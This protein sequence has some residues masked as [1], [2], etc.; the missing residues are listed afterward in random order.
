MVEL[1][2]VRL[3][4][5]ICGAT[6][7]G[8]AH[9]V[10]VAQWHGWF[11]GEYEPWFLNSG[12]AIVFTLSC[13][14]VASMLIALLNRPGRFVRGIT[15]GGGAVAAMSYIVFFTGPGPGTLFPIVLVAGGS[16]VLASSTLGAWAG[17]RIVGAIGGQR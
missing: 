6:A 1:L 14:A 17:R 3:I 9:A 16:L 11:Q 4:G 13:V 8:A 2:M 7:F 12:R 10:E 5:F 15:V